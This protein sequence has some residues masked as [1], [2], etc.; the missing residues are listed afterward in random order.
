MR[1]FW[2]R[3]SEELLRNS[4]REVL[5]LTGLPS[6]KL[7]SHA[8]PIG[9]GDHL[10]TLITGN[11][12]LPPLVLVHGYGAGIGFWYRTLEELSQRFR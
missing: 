8:V 1:R 5:S 7:R 6:H 10:N 4:E 9:N 3:T 12:D 2:Y 11:E